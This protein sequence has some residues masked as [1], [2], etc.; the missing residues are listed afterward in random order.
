MKTV[1]CS[2]IRLCISILLVLFRRNMLLKENHCCSMY[3]F[4]FASSDKSASTWSRLKKDMFS[5]TKSFLLTRRMQFWQRYWKLIG[6]YWNNSL[7]KSKNFWIVSKNCFPN[8]FFWKSGM[9]FDSLKVRIKFF[10]FFSQKD[11]E[12]VPL[13]TWRQIL[14]LP[15][16]V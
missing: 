10:S 7:S 3:T 8:F 15:I 13:E 12:N 9:Q 4:F 1:V 6:Q 14:R 2:I 11:A 16:F 5:N